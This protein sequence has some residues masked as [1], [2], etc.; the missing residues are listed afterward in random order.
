MGRQ[1][2]MYDRSEGAA[3]FS[4]GEVYDATR[5][6]SDAECT[7]NFI[8]MGEIEQLK[9]TLKRKEA[10]IAALVS[11]FNRDRDG[12]KN[13]FWT[14][15]FFESICVRCVFWLLFESEMF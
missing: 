8:L 13:K 3:H 14:F 6:T 7:R 1:T 15:F 4:E 2:Y 12:C 11:A 9:E 5:S 10:R